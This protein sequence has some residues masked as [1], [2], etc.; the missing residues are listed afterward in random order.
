MVFQQ[1]KCSH[2]LNNVFCIAKLLIFYLIPTTDLM[3]IIK[4]LIKDVRAIRG[5]GC[6]RFGICEGLLYTNIAQ[7]CVI[8]KFSGT[9]TLDIIPG[10]ELCSYSCS[11][12]ITVV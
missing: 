8:T 12:R 6:E 10:V 3:N 9:Y 2:M 7:C 5:Y 1:I 4:Y 11:S